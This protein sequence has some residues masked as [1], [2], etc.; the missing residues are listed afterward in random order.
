M[1]HWE[2]FRVYKKYIELYCSR[3]ELRCQTGGSGVCCI[4]SNPQTPKRNKSIRG[5]HI[6]KHKCHVNSFAIMQTCR[7]GLFLDNCVFSL[8]MYIY[9]YKSLCHSVCQVSLSLSEAM[10]HLPIHQTWLVVP[11]HNRK[12]EPNPHGTSTCLDYNLLI[13]FLLVAVWRGKH[14]LSRLIS[15]WGCL[16]DSFFQYYRD[17]HGTLSTSQAVS[18]WYLS[19]TAL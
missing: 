1:L 16:I 18:L 12:W 14:V 9:I 19:I 6:L 4:P 3:W 2:R 15:K 8:Y 5:H 11:F 10:L 7:H 13:R 17:N